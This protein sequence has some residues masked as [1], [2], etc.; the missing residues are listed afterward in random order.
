[1]CTIGWNH[2]VKNQDYLG[3]D[4][5][6]NLGSSGLF[7]SRLKCQSAIP[8][9]FLNRE[10]TGDSDHVLFFEL[11]TTLSENGK[12]SHKKKFFK[13]FPT[14]SNHLN[15]SKLYEVW[16]FLSVYSLCFSLIECKY[17]FYFRFQWQYIRNNSI[18]SQPT[19][20]PK[21]I[22]RRLSVGDIMIFG[23]AVTTLIGKSL[24]QSSGEKFQSV[25]M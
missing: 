10:R 12:F 11:E 19:N 2:N 25:N 21:H 14:G 23:A 3:N 6:V 7:Y 4:K 1:M 15:I 20:T 13:K 9:T 18:K 24:I 8:Y 22:Q 5:T 16:Y 17:F